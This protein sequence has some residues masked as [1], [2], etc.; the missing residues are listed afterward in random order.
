MNKF[1]EL[2]KKTFIW[3]LLASHPSIC[4]GTRVAN[5]CFFFV[6]E[7]SVAGHEPASLADRSVKLP[8]CCVCVGRLSI[9]CLSGKYSALEISASL[10][11]G[12]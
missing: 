7:L 10:K 3:S 8:V 5:G 12:Q 4:K 2:L 1:T 9:L 11:C 6:F